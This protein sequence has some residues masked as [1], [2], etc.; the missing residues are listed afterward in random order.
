MH[1]INA[2]H[3]MESQNN[4]FRIG[5]EINI[6]IWDIV[7]YHV[8]RTLSYPKKDRVKLEKKNYKSCADLR[9][10]VKEILK[11]STL[12]KAKKIN[13]L[14]IAYSRHLNEYGLYFDKSALPIIDNLNKDY[15]IIESNLEEKIAYDAIYDMSN[16]VRRLYYPMPLDDKYFE[17]I[18]TVLFDTFGQHPITLKV[19]NRIIRTY[20]SQ[21]IFYNIILK[22][23]RPQ[24]MVI[25][26]GNPK[27]MIKAAIKNDAETYLVQHAGIEKDVV[28]IGMIDEIE[29]WD[30]KTLT[31][32]EESEFQL[33]AEDIEAIDNYTRSS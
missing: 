29:I 11:L 26:T 8:F 4:L 10:I 13:T 32:Y 16:L 27:G 17:R 30:P 22:I 28:I 24:K 31:R 1:L 20:K 3:K 19:F 15:L 2:F 25:C 5:E 23:S 33:D 9:L 18:D 7:R 14:V 12:F 6:P 21:Y